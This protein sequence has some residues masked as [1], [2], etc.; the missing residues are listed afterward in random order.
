M[1]W[2]SLDDCCSI[3][4]IDELPFAQKS[5]GGKSES[6]PSLQNL[7]QATIMTNNTVISDPMSQILSISEKKLRQKVYVH[8]YTKFGIE[9]DDFR[10]MFNTVHGVVEGY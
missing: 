1:S 8:W 9:E 7:R 4:I 5:I 2:N 10:Q 3:R 6:T